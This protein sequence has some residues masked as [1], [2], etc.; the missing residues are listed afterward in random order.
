MKPCAVN[1]HR[2]ELRKRRENRLHHVS[3]NE[4]ILCT[5][6]LPHTTS[7]YI[8]NAKETCFLQ[9]VCVAAV[10]HIR[11]KE[12]VR[13]WLRRFENGCGC[14]YQSMRPLYHNYHAAMLQRLFLRRALTCTKDAVCM[15]SFPLSRF[16]DNRVG[17]GWDPNDVD[18]FVASQQT[19]HLLTQWY[20][21]MIIEPLGL[22]ISQTSGCSFAHDSDPE[23]NHPPL[24][25]A[26]A[27]SDSDESSCDCSSE[28]SA[29]HAPHVQ[30]REWLPWCIRD[31]LRRHT[32][33]PDDS[34]YL[35]EGKSRVDRL[36]QQTTEH[37]PV[38]FSSHKS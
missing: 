7:M 15:G 8:L 38:A 13:R 25:C 35:D 29:P 22:D 24:F 14:L 26:S 27:Y 12:Y 11:P 20:Q 4:V 19:L 16:I 34:P 5:V 33:F 17:C 37:L 31:W 9:S 21:N 1:G 23:T 18:I 36:L 3:V 28:P 32:S 10:C 6:V 30:Y 2:L